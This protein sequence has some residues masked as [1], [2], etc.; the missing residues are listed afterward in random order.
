VTLN[1]APRDHG[2]QHLDN[3][4]LWKG[5]HRIKAPRREWK[6]IIFSQQFDKVSFE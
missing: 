5:E 2:L 4:S 6:V 3:S 1:R